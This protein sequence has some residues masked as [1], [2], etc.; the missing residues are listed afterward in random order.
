LPIPEGKSPLIVSRD[1]ASETTIVVDVIPL[2]EEESD[3]R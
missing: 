3:E 1:A 2:E